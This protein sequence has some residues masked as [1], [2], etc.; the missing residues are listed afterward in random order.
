MEQSFPTIDLEKSP[1][2]KM[3]LRDML[4]YFQE[5]SFCIADEDG[6]LLNTIL[7][8]STQWSRDAQRQRKV[9]AKTWFIH[10]LAGGHLSSHL[11]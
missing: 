3:C 2:Q 10:Q 9:F 8:D 4:I 7:F 5:F 11:L 6:S 1:P